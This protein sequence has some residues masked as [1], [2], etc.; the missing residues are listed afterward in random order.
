[1]NRCQDQIGAIKCL[2]INYHSRKKPKEYV[3]VHCLVHL[4]K[5]GVARNHFVA[6]KFRQWPVHSRQHLAKF[7]LILV[8]EGGQD[9]WNIAGRWSKIKRDHPQTKVYIVWILV[10]PWVC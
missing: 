1:M 5:S 7:N 8:N 6:L 2:N 9:E 3:F 10:D 4:E